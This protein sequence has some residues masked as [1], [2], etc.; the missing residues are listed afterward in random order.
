MLK[1]DKAV[2]QHLST[3][4]LITDAGASILQRP[5]CVPPPPRWPDGSP[6]FLI[7]MHLKCCADRWHDLPVL[8]QSFWN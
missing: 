6:Q 8:W 5:W 2:I 7:I 4:K 3:K 1:T